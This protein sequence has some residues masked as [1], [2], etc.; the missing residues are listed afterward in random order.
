MIA[1]ERNVRNASLSTPP[2]ACSSAQ[3]SSHIWSPLAFRSRRKRFARSNTGPVSPV[4]TMASVSLLSTPP[5]VP[6]CSVTV[7]WVTHAT[8]SN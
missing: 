1:P 2:V 5:D 3:S 7:L 6:S 4:K 8:S